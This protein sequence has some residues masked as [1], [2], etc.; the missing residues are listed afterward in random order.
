MIKRP[1][2]IIDESRSRKNIQNMLNKTG[3]HGK[4]LR[5]HF[6]TH[7][8]EEI[9]SWFQEKGIHSC[10]VSSFPM[11]EYFA[12][13]GWKDILIAFPLIHGLIHEYEKLARK[14]N[15]GVFISDPASVDYLNRIKT[16]MNIFIELDTG[17]GRSGIDIN[18]KDLIIKVA[19]EIQNSGKHHFSGFATHNGESYRTT[20]KTEILS[21]HERNM[22]LLEKVRNEFEDR[23]ISYGDTPSLILGQEFAPVTELRPGNFVFFDQMQVDLGTCSNEEVAMQVR[24][25]VVAVYSER[26]RLIIHGGAVHLSKE[27]GLLPDHRKHYGKIIDPGTGNVIEKAFVESLSQEHGVV[28]LPDKQIKYY[29]TGDAILISPVHSCLVAEIANEYKEKTSGRIIPKMKN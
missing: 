1:E 9:A 25:P 24:C 11:A 20:S 16:P 28:Y 23:K 7:Q 5:P 27:A 4:A 18:K 3:K 6:K 2:V 15:L 22:K 17:D 14:V 10:A 29:K 26:N 13:H 21:I 8:S 12:S 19:D